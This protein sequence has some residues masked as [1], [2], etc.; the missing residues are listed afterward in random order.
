MTVSETWLKHMTWF[1]RKK[2]MLQK[3]RTE[4]RLCMSNIK[5]EDP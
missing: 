5:M 4:M 3:C 1:Y 2:K